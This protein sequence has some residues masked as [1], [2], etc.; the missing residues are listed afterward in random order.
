MIQQL[1][2]SWFW[3]CCICFS[4]SG[5]SY[6]YSCHCCLCW[7][8]HFASRFCCL[9][10]N[11]VQLCFQHS[12]CVHNTAIASTGWGDC[13][14]SPPWLGAFLSSVVWS[15]GSHRSHFHYFLSHHWL[16]RCYQNWGWRPMLSLQCVYVLLQGLGYCFHCCLLFFVAL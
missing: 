15:L 11:I 6:Y 13:L 9:A 4:W 5:S 2:N 14:T 12:T 7:C 3:S 8:C 16:L 10:A 1:V